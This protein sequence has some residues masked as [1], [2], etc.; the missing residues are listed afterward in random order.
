MDR[1]GTSLPVPLLC[2]RPLELLKLSDST[3]A[4]KPRRVAKL[5]YGS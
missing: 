2:L 4:L 5:D 3:Q 1:T